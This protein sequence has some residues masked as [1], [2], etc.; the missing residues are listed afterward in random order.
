MDCKDIDLITSRV[1]SIFIDHIT[2][3]KDLEGHGRT[4]NDISYMI[5]ELKCTG[6]DVIKFLE[7]LK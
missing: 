6:E 2:R 5:S 3:V 7:S 1:N 4:R